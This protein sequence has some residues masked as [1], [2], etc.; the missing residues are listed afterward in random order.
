[1]ITSIS[2]H[3]KGEMLPTEMPISPRLSAQ[4]SANKRAY[5]ILLF[6]LY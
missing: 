1:M 2:T 6:V 4:V 3:R 5:K